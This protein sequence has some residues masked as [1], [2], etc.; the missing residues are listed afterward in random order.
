MTIQFQNKL[1]TFNSQ[2]CP[3]GSLNFDTFILSNSNCN[4]SLTEFY[5]YPL[6]V[7]NINTQGTLQNYKLWGNSLQSELPHNYTQLQ[8]IEATGEQYI[9]TEL[10]NGKFVHD[11]EFTST[12]RN[13]MGFSTTAGTYWGSQQ[14]ANNYELGT[15]TIKLD[16]LQRNIITYNTL[17]DKFVLEVDEQSIEFNKSSI[18]NS[19]YLFRINSADYHCKAKLFEF[20]AYN[21]LGILVQSLIPAKRHSDGTVGLYDIISHKFY[22]NQGKGEFVA[23]PEIEPSSDFPMPIKGVGVKTKNLFNKNSTM[24]TGKFLNPDG[25]ITDNRFWNITDYISVNGV[26]FTLT[27]ADKIGVA[28]C[29]VGYDKNKN[30]I[31]SS[32]YDNTNTIIHLH[33]EQELR[34]IRFCINTSEN[35]DLIQLEQGSSA[36]DYEQ[37]GCIINII[38]TSKDNLQSQKISF[39]LNEQ[40]YRVDDYADYIDFYNQKVIRN[41]QIIDNSGT[42]PIN[43]SL[44]LRA[45]PI[46]EDVVIPE[47]PTFKGTTIYTIEG[48]EPYNMYAKKQEA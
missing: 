24:V 7:K 28:P 31:T 15:S 48:L 27:R 35:L 1:H 29:I 16:T 13:L 2:K 30:K 9:D 23:G 12:D 46:M 40:L 8:Y 39:Y 37:Y 14:G 42:K 41:I 4:T 26:D 21:N 38:A 5:G 10:T 18:V 3:Q 19:Y 36:T 11:I 25:T 32:Q 44:Q 47:L 20:N 34:Y 43:D 45:E 33:S 22:I 6:I 17:G